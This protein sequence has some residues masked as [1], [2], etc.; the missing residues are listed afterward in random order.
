MKITEVSA[1]VCNARMRNW[2]FVKVVTDQPGLI[3][4][5]EATLEWHTNGVVG[6]IKDLSELLVGEDPR[7]IEHLWQMMYR[8]H[9][10]HGNGVVRSTAISG[11][12]I[13]LWDIAGKIHGVPCHQLWGGRVRDYVKMYC[14]LGGGSM[15]KFYQTPVSDYR[16]FA[17]LASAAVADG[18][19]AMKSMAV[20]A[21]M[22]VEG[23][24]AVRHAEGCVAA[25]REAVG[26]DVDLMVD[27]H[28]R[29]SPAMGLRF[30]K[31][32][33][34]YGLLFLEEPC[35]PEAVEGLARI[36]A[37]TT[38]P[39][40]TGERVIGLQQ[41]RALFEAG[42]MDV[43]QLDITHA[44]GLTEAR[45]IAAMADSYRI[46][47]A[48]HNPQGPVS[49]AASLEFGFSQPGYIICESVHSD[50]PWRADIVQ[51]SHPI[52]PVGR[53]AR[54]HDRPGLGIELNE[55]EI[56]KHPYQPEVLQRVFYPDG[57]VG[58]W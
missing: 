5:G 38:T 32:L 20:P 16:A 24:S 37:A 31:A 40:A 54:P 41:F 25:M 11:I 2:I 39:I 27:C 48:P 26:P 29:P 4:W 53:L 10:W 7:R 56:A 21:T 52:D 50:V 36:N 14:H 58:D 44:G 1:V 42:A 55:A 51:E 22:P 18:F 19:T 17:E 9:F 57:A 43:C 34:D 8:Q 6:A 12:D 15:E 23:L 35:W 49:T 3:G 47:L 28:A 13:A 45:K 30:A 33:D 46:A